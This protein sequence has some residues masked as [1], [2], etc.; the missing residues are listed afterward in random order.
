MRL[1]GAQS[2][3]VRPAADRRY[4]SHRAPRHRELRIGKRAAPGQA[5]RTDVVAAYENVVVPA[6]TFKAFKLTSS[7]TLGNENV[8]WF[9][10]QLGLFIRA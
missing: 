10:P 5:W 1:D 6:G 9:S 2:R 3:E 8:T 7:D 4:V